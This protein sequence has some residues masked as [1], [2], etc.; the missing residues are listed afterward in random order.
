MGTLFEG[1]GLLNFD[2]QKWRVYSRG[3]GG[4]SR[5]YSNVM[6]VLVKH[7]IGN[8]ELELVIQRIQVGAE[9]HTISWKCRP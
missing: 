7:H 4:Y 5:Q 9:V 6:H 3:G 2:Q 8:G 1:G